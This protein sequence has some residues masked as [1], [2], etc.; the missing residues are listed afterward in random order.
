MHSTKRGYFWIICIC[1][2][3][4]KGDDEFTDEHVIPKTIVGNVFPINPFLLRSWFTQNTRVQETLRNFDISQV[5]VGPLNFMGKITLESIDG[6]QCDF[7]LGPTG[8][9]YCMATD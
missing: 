6:C 8:K 1:C 9:I 3:Q 5:P 2:A 7:G 4:D